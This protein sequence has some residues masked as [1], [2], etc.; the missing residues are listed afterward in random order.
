MTVHPYW[1]PIRDRVAGH[2]AD[3][4][5]RFYLDPL[6]SGNMIVPEE[7]VWRTE[8]D[9]VRGSPL[10]ARLAADLA[11]PDVL[12]ERHRPAPNLV[13][14]AYHLAQIGADVAALRS[15]VEIGAGYGALCRLV[16]ALGFRGRYVI[17]DLPEMAELQ[18]RYLDLCGS[19]AEPVWASGAEALGA[20]AIGG[21]EILFAFWSLTEFP[22][23]ARGPLLAA[24]RPRR[25]VGGLQPQWLDLDNLQWLAH[26]LGRAYR[27]ET[28][29]IAHHP[30]YWYFDA[31]ACE[32]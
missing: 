10:A 3:D 23:E 5:T 16:H 20:A 32:G 19:P 22:L 29:P 14:Q 30:G 11:E 1:Q 28:R 31:L 18:R 8:L 15:I 24:A 13:H 9:Q 7:R 26:G 4:W 27:V 2:L 21:C 6:V 12:G 25:I 17:Y